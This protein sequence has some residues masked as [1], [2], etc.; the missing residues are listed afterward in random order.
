M[1]RKAFP[2][3]EFKASKAEPGTFE[4]IVS[5]FGN[6]DSG[7]DRVLAGAFADLIA[8]PKKPPVFWHHNWALGPIGETA[9][10]AER[11]KGLWVK[12][13]LFLETDSELVKR[14]HAGM[15]ADQVNE[16]SF[17]YSAGESRFVEEED[18]RTIREIVR[19]AR[20]YELG[21][22]VAGMNEETELLEVA[23]IGCPSC[24][25]AKHA[26][27]AN[28]IQAAHDA[29]IRA[30]CRCDA[31]NTEAAG[32]A[33]RDIPGFIDVGRATRIDALA[34]EAARGGR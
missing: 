17:A 7:N 23:G 14:I 32:L 34:L 3:A 33:P 16:F 9:D 18:G 29:L 11:E 12:G 24:A 26:H 28:H 6:V 22:V 2:V 31:D 27:A 25:A 30:G 10:W 8:S 1:E 20:V 4:A 15:L 21:P 19:F 5:V 13:R